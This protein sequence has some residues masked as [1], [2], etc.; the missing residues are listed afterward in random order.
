MSSEVLKTIL[1][2]AAPI[3]PI[4]YKLAHT[5]I[6]ADQ[7]HWYGLEHNVDYGVFKTSHF[8][9]FSFINE[10]L[11]VEK[12]D[13]ERIHVLIKAFPPESK[14]WDGTSILPDKGTKNLDALMKA[15]LFHDVWY[16]FMEDLAKA[17]NCRATNVQAFADDVL[18][19]LGVGYG[20]KKSFIKPI[21]QILRFGG[22]FYHKIKKTLIL[23]ALTLFIGGCYSVKT[24][25]EI[26]PPEIHFTGPFT[27]EQLNEQYE[28]QN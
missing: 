4:V 24:E 18:K 28:T 8:K 20:A 25:M 6:E 21:Y 2:K 26:E 12:V 19:I 9:G 15:S 10:F 23:V 16:E 5:A 11:V 22:T 3:I 17:A 13:E 14:I 1:S 27:Q 7:N